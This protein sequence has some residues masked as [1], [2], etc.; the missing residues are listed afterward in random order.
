MSNLNEKVAFVTGASRGIGRATAKE[1]ALRGAKVVAVAR[2]QAELDKLSAE[3]RKENL[4]IMGISC[5]VTQFDIL[6]EAVKQTVKMHKKLDILINNAGAIEPICRLADSDPTNWMKAADVNY[7]AV[8]F[9]IR[10]AL[11]HMLSQGGGTI[12]NISSGAALSPREGWS[13]YCSSK[14]AALMLT[15]MTHLEYG[16]LGIRAVGLS[17]G[18]VATDMQV[19]IRAS[20]INPISQLPPNSH[21]PAERPA[22]I[23]AWLCTEDAKEFDGNDVS[24]NDEK[25]RLRANTD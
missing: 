17:P 11:P 12:I 22:N 19:A 7:K 23:I 8:Y 4:N 13:H 24:L 15:K 5:D 20:G 14:A 10:A 16:A 9:G 1:L 2:N 18:T 25:I 3:A 6:N 21:S